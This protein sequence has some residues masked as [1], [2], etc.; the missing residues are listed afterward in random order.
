MFQLP[1]LVLPL[2]VGKRLIKTGSINRCCVKMLKW[3]TKSDNP[4][5]PSAASHALIFRVCGSGI[6][7]GVIMLQALHSIDSSQMYF[8]AADNVCSSKRELKE[9]INIP[10]ILLQICM[11][12]LSHQAHTAQTDRDFFFWLPVISECLQCLPPLDMHS[13]YILHINNISSS[14]FR[15]QWKKTSGW[16]KLVC[17]SF[18][19]LTFR[20]FI[21]LEMVWQ[22]RGYYIVITKDSYTFFLTNK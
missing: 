13:L 5:N 18:F 7:N 19:F 9:H 8:L 11:S 3:Y 22:C 12:W 2:F 16:I 10:L 21:M 6:C 15:I 4:D 14:I 17:F 1:E 20:T